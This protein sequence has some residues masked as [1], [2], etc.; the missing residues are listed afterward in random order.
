MIEAIGKKFRRALHFDFHTSPGID[1]LLANFD[2]E[3]F[4]EQLQSAHIEYINV[5]A[6]CNMGFSYPSVEKKSILKL[7]NS[8]RLALSLI[9]HKWILWMPLELVL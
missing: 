7:V 9:S 5:A 3:K 4:A 2:A 8:T 6:R 1:N